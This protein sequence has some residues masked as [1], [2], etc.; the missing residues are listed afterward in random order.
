MRKKTDEITYG[1][2]NFH[3]KLRYRTRYM[4]GTIAQYGFAFAFCYLKNDYRCFSEY[5]RT[6]KVITHKNNARIDFS[7]SLAAT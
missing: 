6:A 5:L 2:Y 7:M 4:D 1:I 3:N